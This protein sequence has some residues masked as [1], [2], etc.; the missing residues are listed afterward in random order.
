MRWR[1]LQVKHRKMVN[2]NDISINKKTFEYM[3]DMDD[4]FGTWPRPPTLCLLQIVKEW[5][6]SSSGGKNKRISFGHWE[7]I[8]S[9]L[10]EVGYT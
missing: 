4:V 6:N 1:E 8:T 7:Q 10:H 5:Q 9:K 2:H 3:N